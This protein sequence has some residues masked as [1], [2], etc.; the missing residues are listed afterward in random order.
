MSFRPSWWV[1]IA[2]RAAMVVGLVILLIWAAWQGSDVLLWIGLV[3]MVG[4]LI[5]EGLFRVTLRCPN[6][7]HSPYAPAPFTDFPVIR[8]PLVPAP[9]CPSCGYDFE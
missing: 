5:I 4:G 3:V 8:Q 6:C 7:G 2:P 9:T 1:M